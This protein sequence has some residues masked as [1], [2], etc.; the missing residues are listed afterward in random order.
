MNF[1][2]L[3][4]KFESLN[5]L[6]GR[7]KAQIFLNE[8]NV[9]LKNLSLIQQQKRMQVLISKNILYYVVFLHVGENQKNFLIYNLYNIWA[10]DYNRCDGDDGWSL[11][12]N[13]TEEDLQ[14]YEEIK[15]INSNVEDLSHSQIFS[16]K[17][18]KYLRKLQ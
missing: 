5:F 12:P 1:Y 15:K 10:A 17:H 8:V 13:A 2:P 18:F 9:F 3:K 11:N 6:I 4:E 16:K 7:D 14:R